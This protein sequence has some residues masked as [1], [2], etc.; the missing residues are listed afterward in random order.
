MH[1]SKILIAVLFT[2]P[3]YSSSFTLLKKETEPL[4]APTLLV[5]SGIHGNEPG[6]YFA[7]ALLSQY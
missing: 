1:F 6:S 5:I 4:D 7:T 2:C 3:L